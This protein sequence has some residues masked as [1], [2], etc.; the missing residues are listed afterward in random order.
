MP[1]AV[2][3]SPPNLMALQARFVRSRL[4]F[5]SKTS[6][7]SAWQKAFRAGENSSSKLLMKRTIRPELL[8]SDSGT[9]EEIAEALADLQRVNRWFGGISTSEHLL[10]RVA[11]QLQMQRIELLDVASGS[12]DVPFAVAS[13][14]E[15]HGVHLQTTLLD[16]HATHLP[17]STVSAVVGDALDLPF[18]ANSFDLVSC[19]LFAHHLEPMQMKS[20][21]HE[22]LRVARFAL[23]IN[24]LRRSALHLALIVIGRPLFHSS[25]AWRDGVTSIRRAYTE[26]EFR[27]I[28]AESGYRVEISRHYLQR[29]GII[30][31]K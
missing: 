28:L 11:G 29:I 12:G 8:D 9:P 6:A 17:R 16:R 21:V 30:V 20:F 5:L 3:E 24:D 18:A 31:W 27:K 4:T 26:N 22:A 13:R 25:M 2:H 10:R 19:S 23:I 7:L 1:S 14:L 15:R